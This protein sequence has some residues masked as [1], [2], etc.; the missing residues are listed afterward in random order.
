MALLEPAVFV[1]VAA[2][3]LSWALAHVLSSRTLWTLGAGLM[4]VHAVLAFVVFYDGSHSLAQAATMRQTEDLTGIAFAGG[5]Y[6]NYAFLGFWA[7][8]AGWWWWRPDTYLARPRW[9]SLAIHGF[10]FFIILNGA[11]IFADGWA[12]VLGGAAVTAVAL[13][14][15]RR[16]GWPL[17]GGAVHGSRFTGSRFGTKDSR[18]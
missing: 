10:I 4:V 8:D 1:S 5:I 11:V 3:V 15:S 18:H 6:V 16:R 17:R 14:A 2:S 12:R 9:M 13:A 7:A